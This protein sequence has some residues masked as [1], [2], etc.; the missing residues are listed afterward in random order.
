V[1][2][3]THFRESQNVLEVSPKPNIRKAWWSSV[4]KSPITSRTRTVFIQTETY[5]YARSSD[6]ETISFTRREKGRDIW[7]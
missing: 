3:V 5:I 2:P 6:H 7:L 1:Y 4:S